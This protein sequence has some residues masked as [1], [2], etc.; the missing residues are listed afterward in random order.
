VGAVAAGV[1]VQAQKRISDPAWQ[2]VADANYR[3]EN[4]TVT[5]SLSGEYGGA[6]PA[7]A[8]VDVRA[9]GRKIAVANGAVT[10]TDPT[11]PDEESARTTLN[12]TTSVVGSSTGYTAVA[13]NGVCHAQT[14][15]YADAGDSDASPGDLVSSTSIFTVS[16]GT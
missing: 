8:T 6:L 13:L 9:T 10:V 7:G 3:F 16:Y 14:S 2:S 5:T 12:P 4:R 11:K 1:G 15:D